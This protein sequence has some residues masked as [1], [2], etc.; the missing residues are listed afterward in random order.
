MAV[1]I[2][3]Y[4][5]STFTID[6]DGTKLVIDPFFAPNNSAAPV[7][8]DK[9]EA[10]YVLVSHGHFD[11]AADAAAIAK[12]T[13]A[14]VISNAEVVGWLQKQGVKKLHGMNTGGAFTFPFG[15]VQMTIAHHSSGL[16]DGSYGGNPCG[17][18][19]HFNDGS[20][21]YFAGDTALTL[22][23][24]LIGE[25]GGVDLALL[26]IGD[27]YTMGPDDAVTAAQYVKAKRVI[28][29]HYNT[30]PVIEQDPHAFAEMLRQAAEIDCKV[31]APGETY[32]LE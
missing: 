11:H 3:Y 32:C 21:V 30:F 4:G 7:K 18:L 6:A 29:M 27:N 16:P 10:D 28:P 25:A 14:T 5:H 23:M 20:D 2:T 12:R 26:P 1:T 22:D 9:I 15:R 24:K 8:A 31:L 13:G 17:L 19:F